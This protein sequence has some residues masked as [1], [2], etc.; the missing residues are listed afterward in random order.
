M[1]DISVTQQQIINDS[2]DQASAVASEYAKYLAEKAAEVSQK[3]LQFKFTLKHPTIVVPHRS[4]LFWA[5]ALHLGPAC[6]VGV[7]LSLVFVF[8][9]DH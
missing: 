4:V 9:G 5:P 6:S 7:S 1:K 2:Y 3:L 8:A